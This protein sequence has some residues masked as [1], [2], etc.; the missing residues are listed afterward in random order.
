M[1]R[2]LMI[3]ALAAGALTTSFA[4]VAQP[5]PASEAVM[6]VLR[7]RHPKT[8][9]TSVRPAAIPG[10]FEVQ[11]GRNLAYT[12]DSGRY[13]IFGSMFD[14]QE[15]VDI[16][17]A[18]RIELGIQ[19][20]EAQQQ[21]QRQAPPPNIE[22]SS[23]PLKDAFVK[24]KGNGQRKLAV[25]SDPDCPFCKRLEADLEKV[26]N[27]TIYTFLNPIAQLHPDA[28][29]KAEAVWCAGNDKARN[30]LWSDMML[31]GKQAK[32]AKSCP[33]PIQRNIDLAQSLN[34]RGTPTMFSADG[35][36]LVGYVPSERI[37]A[38]LNE[39]KQ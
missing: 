11:M 34:A 20:P 8:T 36:R 32:G 33:N 31:R 16:T 5:D 23:L 29:T 18:R 10:M 30:A 25:F 2:T 9:F 12:D 38:F 22:W 14:M 19:Q 17:A 4:A 37:E 24:V 7:E 39:V 15:R 1:K 27:V 35:R 3:L 13:F 28:A 6:R 21:A 26:D